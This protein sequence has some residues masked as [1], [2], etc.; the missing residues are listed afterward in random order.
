MFQ[1][2]LGSLS[3]TGCMEK[4]NEI[5]AHSFYIYKSKTQE[6]GGSFRLPKRQ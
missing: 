5:H 2:S 6:K 3:T 1:N 4:E